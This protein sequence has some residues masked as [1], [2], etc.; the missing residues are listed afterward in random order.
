MNALVL[1]LGGSGERFGGKT[2]KQF[3]EADYEGA[4]RH[5]FDITARK[6]LRGLPLDILI[7]VSPK[8]SIGLAIV[9][10]VIAE[11]QK[12][13]PRRKM[14]HAAAGATRFASFLNGVT[15]ARKVPGIECLIV[16]DANRPYLSNEFLER[17]SIHLS[18]LSADLPAF[19]PVLPAVD[20]MVRLDGRNVMSYESRAEIA[21]VQ[22][23]QMLHY[24]TFS[25]AMGAALGRRQAL[26]DFTDEGSFCLSL[27][28]SVATFD[29]DA[30]NVKITYAADL[31]PGKL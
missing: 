2:P 5:L 6:L 19:I 27:G 13:F 22:T 25:G 21:R 15:A 26:G 16:H 23:P 7:F 17:V 3:I 11:L 4:T 10:P 29:G 14:I 28:L 8:D 18:Y 30:A 24:K 31:D 20:S 1:L 9:K 12:D